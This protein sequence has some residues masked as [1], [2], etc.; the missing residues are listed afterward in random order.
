M[1][2][3]LVNI[4]LYIILPKSLLSLLCLQKLLF[5]LFKEFLVKLKIQKFFYFHQHKQ[6]NVKVLKEI[7]FLLDLLQNQYTQKLH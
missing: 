7:L 6:L 2:D 3:K 4:R 5:F 1:F